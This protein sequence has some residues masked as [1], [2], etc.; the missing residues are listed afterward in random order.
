MPPKRKDSAVSGPKAKRSKSTPIFRTPTTSTAGLKATTTS[1][2]NS[3]KNRVVT[4]RASAS[5]RRGYRTQDLATSSNSND[6]SAA[7]LPD[8]PSHT[9]DEC[10]SKLDPTEESNIHIRVKQKNTTTVCNFFLI[11]DIPLIYNI[12]KTC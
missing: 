2:I 12:D 3:T 11:A 7:E 5:G 4:L 9:P 6:S 1:E 10:K 8:L